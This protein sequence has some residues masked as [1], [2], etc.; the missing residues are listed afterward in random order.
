MFLRKTGDGFQSQWL[1]VWI[2]T[3]TGQVTEE[4]L[5][6]RGQSTWKMQCYSMLNSQLFMIF[7]K[8]FKEHHG[9]SELAC[10]VCSNCCL[11]TCHLSPVVVVVVFRVGSKIACSSC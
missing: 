6:L 4:G 7:K 5:W 2:S 8:L 3:V 1:T 10:S 11:Q 9:E